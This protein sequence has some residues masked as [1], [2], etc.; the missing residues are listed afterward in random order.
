MRWAFVLLICLLFPG[1]GVFCQ[2]RQHLFIDY[3]EFREVDIKDVLRQISQQYN[4]N[5]VFSEAVSGLVT[6]QLQNITVDEALDSIITVNGFSYTKKENVIKVTTAEEADREA[7]VT[8]VFKLGNADAF[9]LK[10]TLGKVLSAEGSIQAD[11]RSN[12]IIVTDT[13]AV[14]NEIKGMMPLLDE[15]TTQVLIEARFVET[16]LGATEKMGIDWTTKLTAKGSKRPTTVPFNNW[17]AYKDMYPVPE[18]SVTTDD[19]GTTITSGFPSRGLGSLFFPDSTYSWGSFPK[20]AATE[21]TFGTLD[22]SAYQMIMQFLKTDTNSKLISSP[23]I[24]TMDNKAAEMY[25]GTARPIPKF[26][27][28]SDTAEYQITGFTEKIEGVTLTVTPQ[29][30]VVSDDKEFIRLKLK[31]KVTT[32]TNQSVEFTNLGFSYPLLSERFAD[33]EVMIKDGQTIVIGGLIENK[34]TTIERKVPFL[35]DI[36]ILGLLFK[37]KE[38]DPNSKT[39]LLIFVTA[40]ILKEADSRLVGYK[41]DLITSYPRPFKLKEREIAVKE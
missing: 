8:K 26:E 14:I 37:Y 21:F 2:E 18:Y 41:S 22:F 3:M 29:V 15:L 38:T 5:I 33:T 10:E 27:Y 6:V 36:P 20:A 25:I 23:R 28:N 17:G 31:P 39:E 12:A 40:R 11:A 34:T 16:I 19:D 9:S 13:P 24:V 4:L 32:F 35:G 7:K 1:R 30:N